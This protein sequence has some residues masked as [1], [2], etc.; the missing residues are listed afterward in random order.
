M[1]CSKQISKTL[2]IQKKDSHNPKGAGRKPKLTPLE[3][4]DVLNQISSGTRKEII[5]VQYNVSL[6]T[7]ER[8]SKRD[9][10]HI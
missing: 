1:S 4:C 7:I 2:V 10:L 8:I 9:A 6:K 3:I 5:A